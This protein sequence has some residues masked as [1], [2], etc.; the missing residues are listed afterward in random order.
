M[1]L[2]K[3]KWSK[4]PNNKKKVTLIR[5]PSY[6]L[7]KIRVANFFSNGENLCEN[8]LI[9]DTNRNNKMENRE[10]ENKDLIRSNN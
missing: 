2:M 5:M 1:Y 9:R 6:I 7:P 4:H 8:D 3:I 10:M